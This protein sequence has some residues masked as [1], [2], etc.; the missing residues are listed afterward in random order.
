SEHVVALAYRLFGVRPKIQDG[1][2]GERVLYIVITARN[3]VEFLGS[4]GLP[5]G[6]KMMRQADLPDWIKARSELARAC[7]RGLIDTDGSIYVHRHQVNGR[8]Y[9]NIGLCFTSY[10]RPLLRSVYSTLSDIGLAPKCDERHGRVSLY[11]ADG[12]ARY[13]EV[14][15]TSNPKH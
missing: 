10:S 8:E 1:R 7:V 13:L 6:N 4:R 2:A 9:R 15:G 12:V 5:P 14:V 3:L 11:S